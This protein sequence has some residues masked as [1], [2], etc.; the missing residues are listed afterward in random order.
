MLNG[1]NATIEVLKAFPEIAA[2]YGN[3]STVK[4]EFTHKNQK[5]GDMD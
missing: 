3:D 4:L 2:K 1:T 5:A